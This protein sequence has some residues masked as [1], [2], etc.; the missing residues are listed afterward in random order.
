MKQN[1][2]NKNH[3]YFHVSQLLQQCY[4]SSCLHLTLK[5]N[6]NFSTRVDLGRFLVA[7]L[8][9][10][11]NPM[12]ILSFLLITDFGWFRNRILL[13][14]FG[15]FR[16]RTLIIHYIQLTTGKK[17]KNTKNLVTAKLKGKSKFRSLVYMTLLTQ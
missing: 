3:W 6:C 17:K 8:E 16:N 10:L 4:C 14:D 7:L 11:Y 15:W 2:Q 5:I 12:S 9:E 13:I 1:F